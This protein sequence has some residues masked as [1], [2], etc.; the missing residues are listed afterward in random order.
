MSN[1]LKELLE[2]AEHWPKLAQQE[3]VASLEAIEEDFVVDA[4]LSGDL[5]RA[6]AEARAGL[7]TPLEELFEQFGV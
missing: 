2:R 7:G 6:Q 4:T 3:A 1:K 5:Q